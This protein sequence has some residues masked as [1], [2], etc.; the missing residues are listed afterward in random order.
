MIAGRGG[1]I[2]DGM[3]QANRMICG[4]T[5]DRGMITAP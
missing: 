4:L 5:A 1:S 2:R 3:G